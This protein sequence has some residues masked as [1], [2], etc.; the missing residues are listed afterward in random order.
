MTPALS[1]SVP[2]AHGDTEQVLTWFWLGIVEALAF[3][4]GC[5]LADG[6]GSGQ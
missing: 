5:E 1:V 4:V 2:G 6:R 3:K